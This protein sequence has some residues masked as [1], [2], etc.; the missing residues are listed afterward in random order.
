MIILFHQV[1]LYGGTY[2]L[3]KVT[4]PRLGIKVKFVDGDEPAEFEKQID[5]NTKAIYVES[6]GNPKLNIPD[7]EKIADVA[8]KNG[9]PLN[10]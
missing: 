3:F 5:E 7:F 8:H 1:F 10:C 2:N 9:I 4:L 6:I